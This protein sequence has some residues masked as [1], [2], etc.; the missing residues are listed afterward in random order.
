MYVNTES[1]EFHKFSQHVTHRIVASLEHTI[2]VA[3]EVCAK[4]NQSSQNESSLTLSSVNSL[5]HT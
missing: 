5:E 2:E 1:V 3:P 4:L